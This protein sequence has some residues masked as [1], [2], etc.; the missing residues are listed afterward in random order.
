MSDVC[1]YI[2]HMVGLQARAVWGSHVGLSENK[3]YLI[4]G[5]L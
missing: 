1:Q 3:G 4:L 2:E 5:S